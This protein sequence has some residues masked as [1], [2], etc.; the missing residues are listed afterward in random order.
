MTLPKLS[1]LNRILPRT[2]QLEQPDP[3]ELLT[4]H[5]PPTISDA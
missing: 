4:Y 2:V 1:K 5:L 3:C